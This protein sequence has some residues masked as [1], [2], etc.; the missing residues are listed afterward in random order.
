MNFFLALSVV[1][2]VAN[3]AMAL[4]YLHRESDVGGTPL[5][6]FSTRPAYGESTM[7]RKT[8]AAFK[9][10]E[11]TQTTLRRPSSVGLGMRMQRKT[12]L[13]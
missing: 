9:M 4:I 11:T 12:S 6:F 8:S 5:A 13:L 3:V 2:F 1:R 7:L 10:Q